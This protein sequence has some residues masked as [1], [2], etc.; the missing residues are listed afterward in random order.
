MTDEEA[1]LEF[2]RGLDQEVAET[3]RPI[4]LQDIRKMSVYE[5]VPYLRGILRK[6]EKRNG[7]WKAHSPSR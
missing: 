7:P 6:L 1:L 2:L 5:E 4:E 3:R